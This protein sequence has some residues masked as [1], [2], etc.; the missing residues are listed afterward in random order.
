MG[1]DFVEAFE[2]TGFAHTGIDED[3]DGTGAKD[4]EGE[5]DEFDGRADHEHES[6]SGLDTGMDE[7]FGGGVDVC[8]ELLEG[9]GG[10]CGA[11]AVI[12]GV[13]CCDGV[14]CGHEL[15]GVSEAVGDIEHGGHLDFRG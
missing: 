10:P 9:D 15:C 5:G 2:D 14:L 6:M 1:V 11:S 13:G 7:S 3:A 4:S 8:V 12:A